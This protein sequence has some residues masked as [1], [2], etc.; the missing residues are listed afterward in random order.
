[1]AILEKLGAEDYL[2]AA[3]LAMEE[4]VRM[5]RRYADGPRFRAEIEAGCAAAPS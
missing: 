4:I 5:M 3:R 2:F 1:M